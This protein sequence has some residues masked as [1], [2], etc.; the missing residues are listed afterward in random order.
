ME[1]LSA[2]IL[3]RLAD[4]QKVSSSLDDFRTRIPSSRFKAKAK[5]K[6]KIKLLILT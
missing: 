3:N 4:G 5:G 6:L 2:A 1:S